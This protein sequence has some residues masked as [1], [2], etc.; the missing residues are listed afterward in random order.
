MDPAAL[1]PSFGTVLRRLRA[2]RGMTQ[3]DLAHESGASRA[4]IARMETGKQLP[5]LPT[6]LRL[7]SALGVNASEVLRLVEEDVSEHL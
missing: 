1:T 2:G 3:E 5:S 6:L 4:A 7:S